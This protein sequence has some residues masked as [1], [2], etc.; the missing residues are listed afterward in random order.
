VTATIAYDRPMK[1]LIDELSATGHVTHTSYRKTMVTIHHNGGRLTH[2]GCLNV[3]KVRPAS[4]HFDIDASGAACQYVKVNEYAW[5]CANGTGNR[6]SI[7]IEMANSAIGGQWPVSETTW[8]SAA[9]LAGW[10]FAKVIGTRPTKDTLVFHSH[11]YPTACA[12]PYMDSVYSRLL[13]E[14][15]KAYDGFIQP[16]LRVGPTLNQGDSGPVVKTLQIGLNKILNITLV[17]D[18][19]FGPKTLAAV[20][21]YQELRKLVVDGR[22]GPKTQAALFRDGVRLY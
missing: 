3:W 13:A 21:K 2:E 9:R 11:W 16:V 17:P 8:K 12:G 1:N 14:T 19:R 10:L 15:Q 7:S 5:A 4:A 6:Q 20:K 18:G 22:V